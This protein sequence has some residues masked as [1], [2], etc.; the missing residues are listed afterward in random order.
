MN[1]VL[2][3]QFVSRINLK[4]RE[5]K[6]FTYGART[7]FDWR[8]GL[9]PFALH[10]SVH[11]ASTA[12]AVSDALAESDGIRG[13]RP[14]TATELS[15]AKASLLT[16]GY[17]RAFETVQQV[18]RSVAQLALHRPPD[19]YFAEFVPNVNAVTADDVTARGGRRLPRSLAAAHRHRRGPR[20]DRVAAAGARSRHTRDPSAR[21]LIAIQLKAGAS[22]AA[23]RQGHIGRHGVVVG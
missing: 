11:T 23:A 17:P 3:G 16:R 20:P 14:V 7:G 8:R 13:G 5:E 6:A 15:L 4:L 21:Q 1:A 9:A 19:G 2:G 10:T 18:A 12:E 22:S